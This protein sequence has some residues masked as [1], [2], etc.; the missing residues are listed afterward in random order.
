MR[1]KIAICLFMI[2][3]APS[4][5]AQKTKKTV[6]KTSVIISATPQ[7]PAPPPF[8]ITKVTNVTGEVVRYENFASKIIAPRTFD[9]WLPANYS[10]DKKYAVL[11]M[12]DGQNLFSPTDAQG[13][14]DWGIDETLERLIAEKKVRETIVVGI[15]NNEHRIIEYA[16]S[17]AFDIINRKNI[18][19]SALVKPPEGESDKYLRFLVAELKPFIDK[20]YATKTDAANTFIMGSSMGALMSLY[21]VSEYPNTFGS[22]GCLSTQFTLGNGIFLEYMKKFLPAPKN[23]RIYFDVGTK[24]LDALNAPLQLKADEIVKKKGFKLKKNWQSL[25]FDGADHDEKS[26]RERVAIPL[27][28]LLGK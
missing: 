7:K 22:A 28:F 5:F 20:T 24:T 11:Y 1:G 13:G 2:C 6:G 21:A 8:R 4:A 9:V 3:L 14:V 17:K 19:S 12:Q 25:K 26:W 10:N 27:I 16:P 23:H 18:K 15:W